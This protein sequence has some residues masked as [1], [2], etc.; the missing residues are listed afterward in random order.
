[1]ASGCLE[2]PVDVKPGQFFEIAK[3]VKIEVWL[4]NAETN[5]RERR[6]I[7]A[8]AGYVIGRRKSE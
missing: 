6:R 7:D 4:R 2:R 5:K 3:P 1:M 8:Q